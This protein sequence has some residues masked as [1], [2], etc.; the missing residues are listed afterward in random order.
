MSEAVF[1][2]A[3]YLEESA[4]KFPEN[5]AILE[6]LGEKVSYRELDDLSSNL[7]SF[8]ISIGV[9][10]GE[11]IA[12]VLPKSIESLIGIF[13]ILKAGGV[14]V[15]LDPAAPFERNQK[16]ITST[17]PK[18]ILL[19]E[20]DLKNFLP[21]QVSAYVVKENIKI[22]GDR[23]FSLQ[24]IL[25]EQES[26]V[27]Q[28]VSS[29]D[30]AYILH[31]SGST[32]V[33]KGVMITHGNVRSF[34]DWCSTIW[35]VENDDRVSSDTPLHFDP[36]VFEIFMAIKHGATICIT[37]VEIKSD[38]EKL[39]QHLAHSHINIWNTT[40]TSLIALVEY[41]SLG[42]YDFSS[43]KTVISGGDFIPIKYVRKLRE[44]WTTS[45]LFN[46]YGPTEASVFFTVYHIPSLI[47]EDRSEPFPIGR[48]GS[49]C[50]ALILT[51]GHEA[52]PG[53]K[54]LLYVSGP[55]VFKGYWHDPEKTRNSFIT[56][57]GKEWYNTG[58]FVSTDKAGE[59]IFSGREDRMVKRRGFRIEL[60]EI[61]AA[62]Y[63]HPSILELAV[64]AKPSGEETEIV[65]FL[66]TIEEKMSIIELKKFC[67]EHL[68]KYMIPDKFIILP[69]LPKTSSGKIDYQVLKKL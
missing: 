63:K 57:K 21:L 12:I 69:N 40:A 39:A 14:Y 9:E 18:V 65:C 56:Y 16:I 32:G 64:I 20:K 22:D 36:S 47:A 42:S 4:K 6:P 2:L 52:K 46:V 10:S 15:P 49:H 1:N 31:T 30:L 50:E 5:I 24:N 7:A 33:P 29:S 66:T 19:S 13:G 25:Q 43:L 62:L 51:D 35:K 3:H 28:N 37:T 55:P 26:K 23:I 34:I 48:V 58:D 45:E 27:S 59:L 17:E 41:G 61:E 68:P 38:P 53:E 44:Y 60:G 67:V 54:G 11:R 8:L